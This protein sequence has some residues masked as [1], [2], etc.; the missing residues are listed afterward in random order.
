MPDFRGFAANLAKEAGNLLMA[1]YGKI[2]HHE[3]KRATDFKT[4]ADDAS[5]RL[6]RDAIM[7]KFPDHAIISEEQAPLKKDSEYTW[8]IDPL[9]GTIPYT[10]GISDHFSVSIGLVKGKQPIMGVVYAP[11]LKELYAA[12]KGKGAYCNGTALHVSPVTDVNKAVVGVDYGYAERWNILPYQRKLLSAKGV[13]YTVSSACATVPLCLVA[14]G[15]LHAYLAL[16]I[17]QWDMAAAVVINRESGA[18]VTD[19]GGIEWEFGGTSILVA[20][21]VLHRKLLKFLKQRAVD[22]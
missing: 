11:K 21:P 8:V 15:K 18:R 10:F 3:Y 22:A 7:K 12:E 13:T 4:I 6:I 1:Y 17:Q 5:D 14:S 16:S 2:Q 20:N 19:I 9:D